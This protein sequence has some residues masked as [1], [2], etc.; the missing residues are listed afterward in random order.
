M[1]FLCGTYIRL[2]KVCTSAKSGPNQKIRN[3]HQFQGLDKPT[4]K[5]S[6]SL[7][8]IH[9]SVIRGPWLILSQPEGADYAHQI[10]TGN[11]LLPDLPS[12][13]HGR[14]EKILII[15]ILC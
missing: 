13:L 9:P 14:L 5:R 8:A 12:D 4:Y 6:G 1:L 11:S 10:T 15:Y 2:L 7:R 3:F